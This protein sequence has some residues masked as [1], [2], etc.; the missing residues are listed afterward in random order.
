MYQ[1]EPFSPGFPLVY[2]VI[3]LRI[4]IKKVKNIIPSS[5]QD[6]FFMKIKEERIKV[7]L[8]NYKNKPN[9]SNFVLIVLKYSTQD[10]FKY[11]KSISKFYQKL[12]NSKSAVGKLSNRE[13]F[14]NIE[15]GFYKFDENPN[16]IIVYICLQP[17]RKLSELDLKTRIKKIK[18]YPFEMEIGVNDYEL[19]NA[20]FCNLFDYKSGVE[21]FG[22]LKK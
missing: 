10:F 6:H 18:P 4:S 11:N 21:V 3:K 22:N 5:K 19:L 15:N 7:I 17:K 12:T 9:N 8:D 13:W 16:Q 20:Y 14:K 2:I 1:N